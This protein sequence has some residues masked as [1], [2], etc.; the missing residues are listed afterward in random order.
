MASQGQNVI[1]SEFMDLQ[2]VDREGRGDPI[3]LI[4]IFG[5]PLIFVLWKKRKIVRFDFWKVLILDFFFPDN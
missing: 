2:E 3:L 4:L 1:R 5:F